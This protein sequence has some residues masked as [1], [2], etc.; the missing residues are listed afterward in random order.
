MELGGWP[1]VEV[2][3]VVRWFSRMGGSMICLSRG[4]ERLASGFRR[5]CG[6]SFAWMRDEELMRLT[7]HHSSV[8]PV[9]EERLGRY[10]G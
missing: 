5:C 9:I 2:Q 10:L 1:G 7:N 4:P 6:S 8:A 3:V